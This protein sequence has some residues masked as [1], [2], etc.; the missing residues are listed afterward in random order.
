MA[1]F[2][3]TPSLARTPAGADRPRPAFD[4]RP[5]LELAD[6]RLRLA[7]DPPEEK[8]R[9]VEAELR[10]VRNSWLDAGPSCRNESFA[11]KKMVRT[12]A[13]IQRILRRLTAASKLDARLDT[14]Y[15]V[16]ATVIEQPEGIFANLLAAPRLHGGVIQIAPKFLLEFEHEDE[17]AFVIAHE[18]SHFL[19]R[20]EIV[21][22]FTKGMGRNLDGIAALCE[23]EA[24]E[25]ALRLLINAGYDVGRA[26]DRLK[27]MRAG[28]SDHL[29]GAQLDDLRR[30]VLAD[31]ERTKRPYVI[32]PPEPYLSPAIRAEIREALPRTTPEAE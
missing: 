7:E 24:D 2:C 6:S 8:R 25:L 14:S 23:R 26:L 4:L 22:A 16:C 5:G 17:L 15:G 12:K 21:Y 9:E 30:L 31:L 3:A 18:L 13:Y 11:P 19:L 1:F 27:S 10:R 29:G 32:L 20:H 28:D